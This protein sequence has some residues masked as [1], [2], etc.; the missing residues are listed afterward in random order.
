MKKFTLMA[1]IG[2]LAL[3]FSLSAQNNN[4]RRI[5]TSKERAELMAKEL[6]L[7]A[8]ETTKIEALFDKQ[9]KERAKQIE[10]NRATRENLQTDREARRKEMQDL[11]AKAVAEN[12]AQIE[13][14]IGKEKMKEWK[15]LR[16]KRQESRRD[17]NRSERRAPRNGR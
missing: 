7:S 4:P 8:E 11:R 2:L 1:I 17:V 13:A 12:D 15:E 9:D 14:I 16:T 10:E 5:A 6:K 3:S